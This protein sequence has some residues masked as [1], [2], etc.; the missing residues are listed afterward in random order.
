MA[1]LRCGDLKIT[2]IDGIIFDKD[3]TL[4]DSRPFLLA[5]A[6][7]RA[8][9]LSTKQPGGFDRLMAAFGC[10]QTQIAPEGLMAVGS[11]QENLTVA[12]GYLAEAGWNWL[13]ALTIAEECFQA[14]I[15]EF[16]QKARHT[17][18]YPGTAAMLARLAD[19][20]VHLS[21]LS[22][23]S[24]AG[25]AEFVEV[26][27]LQPY[28]AGWRGTAPSDSP[29]PNPTLLLDLCQQLGI[30]PARIAVIGD[31]SVD[32]Q[33][34]HAARAKAFI[35]VSEAWGG[36]VVRAADGVLSTWDDLSID[37]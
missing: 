14:A 3:G 23:D 33:M 9:H 4:A 32:R 12:A 36:P 22:S 37:E 8:R 10:S 13:E 17:P 21:I 27:R 20:P 30:P 11:R 31:T 26:Y 15:A 2:D 25:V 19:H 29:K 18:P 34:A 16:D 7:Q 28:L 24:P 1:N 6:R 5:L 35:S